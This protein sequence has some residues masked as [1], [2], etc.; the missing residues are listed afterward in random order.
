ME[1]GVCLTSPATPSLPLPPNP[2][3]QFTDVLDAHFRFPLGA[4][5]RK[6]VGENEAGAAA[7]RAMDHGDVF[8]GKIRPGL[9][10]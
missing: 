6:I 9:S 5:L 3:G 1:N 8:V 10:F 7:I 2:T 4:Y